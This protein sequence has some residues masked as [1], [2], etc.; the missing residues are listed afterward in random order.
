MGYFDGVTAAYFKTDK[1]GNKVFY[2]WGILGG[3]GYII[4][5]AREQQFQSTIKKFMQVSLPLAISTNLV[6]KWYIVIFIVL[7]VYLAVYTIW[8]QQ[9]TKDF[10][11]LTEN[12]T[13]SE[14]T[15]NS[16][17]YHNLATIWFLIIG[18]YYGL[19]RKLYC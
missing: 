19:L 10:K 5:K 8:M 12:L 16:A 13:V 14:S 15:A 18:S 4:P 1:K 3:K 6:F 7:P 2:P 9:L 11:I 17:R